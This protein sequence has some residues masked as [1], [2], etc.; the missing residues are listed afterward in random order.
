MI[1]TASVAVCS[2]CGRS[3]SGTRD[4]MACLLHAGFDEL[5]G[6]AAPS[7]ATL[8]FGDFEI[9]RREDGSF[10]E[11]GCGAMGVTYRALDK[12]LHRDVA[13]KVVKTP[14]AGGS[15]AVRDR[16][17]REARSAAALRH[18]NVAGVFQ[19]GASPEADRCYYAME[20]IEGE[21]LEDR[22]RREG[23]LKVEL[24]LEIAIQVSRALVA[25]AA[26][27]LI[28]R[29]LKPGNIMLTPADAATQKLE[30]KV[31]DFGLAKATVDAA[32]EMD[33][34]HGGFV[35]TPT[36]ASP[37]QFGAGPVDARSDIYSLGVT[38]WYALTG[39]VPCP[40]KTMEEI[41]TA[42][43]CADLPVQQL[44]AHKAPAPVIKLLSR[45]LSVNPAERP[46]S[47]RELLEALESCRR[48]LARGGGFYSL[49]QLATVTV[50]VAVAAGTLFALRLNRQKATSPPAGN[51]ASSVSTLTSLPEK[52]IAVLPFENLGEN[53]EDPFF[54]DGI[55]DDVLTSL[56]TIRDLKVIS[57]RSVMAYRHTGTRN[58][59]EI[60]EALGVT[61]VLEGS[62]RRAGDRVAVNVQLIDTRSDRQLWAKRYDRTLTDSLGLQGELA[63]EIATT[64]QAT[65]TPQENARVESK[66]TTNT[67]AYDAYL[68]GRAFSAGLQMNRVNLEG[69]IRLYQ[70]AVKLD[71]GFTLA[72]AHLSRAQSTYYWMGYDAS[73]GRLAAAREAVD[74]ALALGPNLP[75]THLALGYYRH[76]G[77]RDFAAALVEFK[78]AE[79]GLP[80]NADVITAVAQIQRRLGHWEEA[81]ETGRRAVELDPRN[82]N[83]S[84]NLAISYEA[85]R[86]FPEVLATV[87]RVLVFEPTNALALWMKARAFW[88]TQDL[89]AVESLLADPGLDHP[90]L[91]GEQALFQR[92]YAAAMEVLSKG[93]AD[94]PEE[95]SESWQWPLFR[96][97]LSQQRAGDGAAARATYE[98]AKQVLQRQLEKV[99][100]D[101]ME[102]AAMHADLGR[103]YAGLG[104]AASAVAEGQRAMAIDPTSKNPL[105]GPGYEEAAAQI[106]ALL[107]DADHAI[108]I[109]KR[110]LQIPY[111]QPINPALLRLDPIWD[112]IRN[113]PRFQEL[114]AEKP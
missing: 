70:E 111:G 65:L 40:G 20:L 38:L 6:E 4:C 102:A 97:G 68:R 61:H 2:I 14:A 43:N 71:P 16:F 18:P 93:L 59:R 92:H 24:A 56:G 36:F 25:A 53:K 3:L 84:I 87:D 104:E 35:G 44:V 28:H 33:L 11:L 112:E 7:T 78:Q 66:P 19:F 83:D 29:D 69:A 26:H 48:R 64:L 91:R 73:P 47:A 13:L 41:R 39:E 31:I 110:L 27:G 85:L 63:K 52:S 107:G 89:E 96:L 108:P 46:A 106:Y 10:W 67:A 34:T 55:Q 114:A 9:A 12:V 21:T 86:R 62:V 77:D 113:D 100:R 51:N 101:S 103:A 22:V 109:L 76:Y 32:N 1:A 23:P 99:E 95:E 58:M 37:E 88:S 81:V 15:E 72:W 45:T 17:L 105:D 8:I 82:I 5:A 60:G 54:A 80:N 57:H 79:Q 90:A 74:R 42:Q 50:V 49:R 94:K 98:R 30:V 75:E